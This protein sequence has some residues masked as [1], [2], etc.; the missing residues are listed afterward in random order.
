MAIQINPDSVLYKHGLVIHN[1]FFN[2]NKAEEGC[3]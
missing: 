1:K 3:T 2:C